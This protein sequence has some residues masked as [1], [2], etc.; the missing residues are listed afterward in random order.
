MSDNNF[1]QSDELR[2]EE[3]EGED[4]KSEER[5]GEDFARD[6]AVQYAHCYAINRENLS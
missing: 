4:S 5:M 1:H 2:N 3:D 6:V